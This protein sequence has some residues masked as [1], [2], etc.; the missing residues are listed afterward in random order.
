MNE[1]FVGVKDKTAIEAEIDALCK[2]YS[3]RQEPDYFR[4]R[5]LFRCYCRDIL[6]MR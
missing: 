5:A 2:K 3:N 6:L 1:I 4:R